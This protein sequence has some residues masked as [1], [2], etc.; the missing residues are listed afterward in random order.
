[1]NNGLNSAQYLNSK[2]KNIIS[3]LLSIIFDPVG[4]KVYGQKVI[5]VFFFGSCTIFFSWNANRKYSSRFRGVKDL[6]RT[7]Y[8]RECIFTSPLPILCLC[9]HF[10][11]EII[12]SNTVNP[13]VLRVW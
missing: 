3:M 13:I 7:Y 10:T 5:W 8:L 6:N 2:L 4:K 1:M 11:H 12:N 9:P